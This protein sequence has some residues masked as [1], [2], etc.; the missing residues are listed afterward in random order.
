VLAVGN[1]P[2]A[3]R[4]PFNGSGNGLSVYGDGRGCNTLTGSFTVKQAVFSAVYNS[5]QNFDG[6]FIQHCEGAT[7]AL[8]G[9]VKYDAEPVTAPPP[10]VTNL[11]AVVSGSGL[12]ITWA[13]P[14]ASRYRYTL[15]RIEPSGTLAGL[16]PIAGGAVSPAP[17]PQRR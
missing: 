13:N 4:Y 8:T 12:A 16:S 3:T 6:T 15:V 11:S 10:G 17:E 5:L 1:Y 9:E 14:T 7:P 2:N